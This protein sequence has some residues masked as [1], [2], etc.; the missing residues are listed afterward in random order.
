VFLI[1]NG[2]LIWVSW[3]SFLVKWYAKLEFSREKVR[4]AFD[5]NRLRS[6]ALVGVNVSMMPGG[7]QASGTAASGS[8]IC[9]RFQILTA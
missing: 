4:G 6:I 5:P 9:C 8:N 7:C 2:L 3:R 1:D